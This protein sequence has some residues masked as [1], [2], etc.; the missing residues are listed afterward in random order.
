MKRHS[1]DTVM[2]SSPWVPAPLLLSGCVSREQADAKLAKGCEAAGVNALL[3]RSRARSNAQSW[4][5]NS[6]PLSGRAPTCA[7]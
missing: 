4:I 3:T 7:M 2:H 6:L 5:R 1:P